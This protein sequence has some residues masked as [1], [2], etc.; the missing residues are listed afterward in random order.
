MRGT[1][2][3]NSKHHDG[4]HWRKTHSI[5]SP[6]QGSKSSSATLPTT[7][8][9]CNSNHQ[10]F[11]TRKSSF[12]IMDWCNLWRNKKIVGILNLFV[13]AFLTFQTVTLFLSF[14]LAAPI[15][16]T[17]NIS[18]SHKFS[19]SVKKYLN[20]ITHTARRKDWH[21]GYAYVRPGTFRQRYPSIQLDGKHTFDEIYVIKNSRCDRQTEL[22][23]E[24][25]S[26]HSLSFLEW[27]ESE[28][29]EMLLS[30]PPI[31]LSH[32]VSESVAHSQS[33]FRKSLKR[34]IAYL[35]T[36]RKVWA[37]ILQNKHERSMVIDD[38]LFLPSL[39]LRELPSILT[40]L[41]QES[42]AKQEPWHLLLMHTSRQ[43]YCQSKQSFQPNTEV[44]VRSAK[45]HYTITSSNVS[46]GT[47]ARAYIITLA[48]AKF[49][50]DH[51]VRYRTNLESEIELLR[52]D[53]RDS[54]NVLE[55]CKQDI[56]QACCI[57]PSYG[58]VTPELKTLDDCS[59]RR[60][61]ELTSS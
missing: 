44:W 29:R 23:R 2:A 33:N 30:N 18:Q 35:D 50:S 3:P 27:R 26:M 39:F 11:V 54:F 24:Y 53:Y 37:H 59:W 14:L 32:L 60:H 10:L 13:F 38:S 25:A 6:S 48:G 42:L 22:F 61:D 15:T 45:S 40:N 28:P 16:I 9:S 41:D 7:Q 43:G 17:G 12:T 34:H 31:S 1:Y 49:L 19:T 57:T 55:A 58:I 56:G 36:H 21:P 47:G 5:A 4:L 20:N 46:R 51:V 52:D 8:G